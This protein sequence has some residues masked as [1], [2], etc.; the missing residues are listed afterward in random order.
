MA[1]TRGKDE[2]I[3]RVRNYDV[4]YKAAV[5]HALAVQAQ[6]IEQR[7]K[8][9]H[10]WQNRTGAAERGLTCTLAEDG[11]VFRLR[12]AH[13]VPYG[14]YLEHSHMGRFAV[15]QRTLRSQWS[16]SLRAV[17]AAV[18]AVRAT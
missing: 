7:M 12:A 1:Q 9:E 13:G 10:L 17:A 3:R 8:T 6:I 2:V 16:T 11:H 18:K 15:L 14:I 5:R 4:R